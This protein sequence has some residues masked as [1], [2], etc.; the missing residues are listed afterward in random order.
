[1]KDYLIALAF[2]C[3][4]YIQGLKNVSKPLDAK[5]EEKLLFET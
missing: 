2:T 5:E 4:Y 3:M 1:M